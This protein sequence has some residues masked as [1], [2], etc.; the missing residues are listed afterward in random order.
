MRRHACY[1]S[2]MKLRIALIFCLFFGL[3]ACGS[4]GSKS[5]YMMPYTDGGSTAP[6]AAYAADDFTFRKSMPDRRNW[7]PWEF[8]YKHCSE[9]GQK[10]YFSKTAYDCSGPYY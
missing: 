2:A 1:N 8:Y 9:A 5:H 3:S 7:K 4:T 10:A 6:A